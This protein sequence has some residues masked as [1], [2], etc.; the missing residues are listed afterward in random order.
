MGLALR[1]GFFALI[2]T[3]VNIAC[4]WVWLAVC[5]WSYSLYIAMALG[6]LGGLI[7]KY[8][9]D[10]KYIFC[11]RVKSHADN[12]GRFVLYSVMGV[13]TTLVF[14]GFELSFNSLF[15]GENAKFVGAVAGLG[16]GYAVKYRLDKRFVFT[17]EGNGRA[18]N[19]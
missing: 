18:A 7:V 10:K 12:L 16:I 17:G 9:L 8:V 11:Y 5:G 3:A 19:S 4:Q 2:A 14:W 1:Y 15:P 13:I 6:T